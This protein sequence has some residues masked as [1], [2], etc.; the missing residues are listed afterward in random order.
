VAAGDF[1]GDGFP[2][3]AV[4]NLLSNDV[5]ILLNDG[6]WPGPSPPPGR[7]GHR[8]RT[9]P[10][11]L[12]VSVVDLVRVDRSVPASAPPLAAAQPGG[13]ANR[14]LLDSDAANGSTRAAG[15]A[16]RALQPSPLAPIFVRV[17]AEGAQRWLTDRLFAAPENGWPWDRS[18]GDGW[19]SEV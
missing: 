12:P 13:D 10:A 16:D 11:S 8:A 14:P 3:L 7:G 9:L 2:D 4:A 15:A 1:N 17:R 18:A 5:S 19:W 6:K